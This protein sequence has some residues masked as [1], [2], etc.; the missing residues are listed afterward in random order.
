MNID[1]LRGTIA[2]KYRTQV[3][4]A[5][6]LGWNRNKI[7]RLVTGKLVPNINEVAQIAAALRLSNCEFEEI[8][9]K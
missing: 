2:E 1:K 3:A 4:F 7:S 6:A 5:D 9:L 8:F